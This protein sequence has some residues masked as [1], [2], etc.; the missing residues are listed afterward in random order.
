MSAEWFTLTSGRVL[1]Q[2]DIVARCPRLEYPAETDFAALL[3]KAADSAPESVD[4]PEFAAAIV[5][6]RVIVL[7]Q[8]CDLVLDGNGV[9]RAEDILVAPVSSKSDWQNENP[10]AQWSNVVRGRM[11]AVIA[12]RGCGLTGAACEPMVVDFA[13]AFTVPSGMI[14]EAA[15]LEPKRLRL[16]PPYREHLAQHFARYI[17]RVALPEDDPYNF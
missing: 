3:A 1:E 9:C 6:M 4:L 8:S 10:K 5:P 14:I 16:I 12:L 17:G 15:A 13:A 7:T 11:P 2:G